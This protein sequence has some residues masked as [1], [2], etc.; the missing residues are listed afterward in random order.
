MIQR[1]VT[2]SSTK[3]A[4][5]SMWLN[6]WMVVPATILFFSIGTGLYV[7]YK[8]YPFKLNPHLQDGDS[9]FPWYIFTSLPSG[10]SVLLIAGIFAAAMSRLRSSLGSSATS[11]CFDIHP[12]FFWKCKMNARSE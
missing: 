11:Y 6:A 3:E 12:R 4:K 10:L 8:T 1:Y 7:Y 9:I 2:A 5:K